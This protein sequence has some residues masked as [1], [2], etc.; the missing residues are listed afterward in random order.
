MGYKLENGSVV[1][2]IGGGPA[3]VSC[4][5][6]L[7]RE[8]RK[9]NKSIKIII[10]EGKDFEKHYNQ[11]VGVLS[12]PFEDLLKDELGISL[13]QVLIKRRISAYNLHSNS[14]EILLK[15]DKDLK[16]TYVIRRV[17][18][19]RF[20]LNYA[21]SLGIEVI[22]SRATGI[23]FFDEEVRVY[24]ESGYLK[25]ALVIGAFGMDEEMFSVFERA[26]S[27]RYRRPPKFLRSFITKIHMD[28][29]FIENRLGDIIY[30]YI[31]PNSIPNIEFGAITPKEDHID[32][33]IAGE[34]VTSK[35]LDQFLDLPEVRDH[36]P[37][38]DKE[39]LSYF[40]GKFPTATAKNPFGNRYVILGNATGWLR[41]FKGKGINTAIITGINAADVI[42]RYG[43]SEAAFKEYVNKCKEFMKDYY[44]GSFVR[45]LTRF[46]TKTN[47]FFYLIELAKND[48]IVYEALFNAVSA[49]KPFKEILKSL[50]NPGLIKSMLRVRGSEKG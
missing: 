42:V 35:D 34:S 2:I 33:N 12:P 8:A 48:K 43:F 46:L 29:D 44:F 40:E 13:P 5:I 17:M 6:R 47:L 1:V 37:E 21:K 41:P 24:H 26:T 16:P 25:A 7:C 14:N 39:R 3:G 50:V 32:I 27:G 49:H 36:I 45:H 15:G 4:G 19:D 9:I 30:A 11:C 38:I 22:N 31:F 10:L 28:K 20:M 23:E 18:F